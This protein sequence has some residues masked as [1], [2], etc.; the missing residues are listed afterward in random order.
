MAHWD[1]IRFFLSVLRH[2]T[3]SGAASEFGVNQTTVSRRIVA[4]E[5]RLGLTLFDRLPDGQRPTAAA[6]ELRAYAERTE[7][8]IEQFQSA[9]GSLARMS[10]QLVRVSATPLVADEI[11][12]PL[13]QEFQDRQPGIRI[14]VLSGDHH[15]DLSHGEADLA[16][17]V[18]DHPR[19]P[20]LVRKRIG[21][22][23]WR[24]YCAQSYIDKHGLPEAG[25]DLGRHL[26]VAGG[27]EL[28][29]VAPL[30]RLNALYPKARI[31]IR[32]NSLSGLVAAVRS[33]V[34]IG[35]LPEWHA[36]ERPDLIKLP[37]EGIATEAG[38]WLLY[39]ERMRDVPAARLF[40]RA[41]AERFKSVRHRLEGRDL[42]LYDV[43]A[44]SAGS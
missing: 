30:A 33:G 25:S 18:G 34:A 26:I 15:A 43:P 5:R 9:A 36:W 1:D 23:V 4:L 38:I 40:R 7:A 28:A 39:H 17:R 13:V 3:A 37:I 21:T 27:G 24:L 31:G 35:P 6:L 20:G 32:C 10:Q 44:E 12:T 2:G 11:L 42:A 22:S 14:E 19:G 8:S 29:R 16:I 41:V